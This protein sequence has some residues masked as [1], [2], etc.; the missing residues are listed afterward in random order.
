MPNQINKIA[1]FTGHTGGIY[2]LQTD[3]ENQRFFTGGADGYV[4]EWDVNKPQEGSLLVKLPQ[5]VYSILILAHVGEAWIGTASGNIHVVDLEKRQE[6]KNFQFHQRGVFDL[7]FVDGQVY[8]AGG[9]GV[10]SC[11]NA[12]TKVFTGSLQLSDKS[13]RSLSVDSLSGIIAAASSDQGIYLVDFHLKLLF[14]RPDSHANSVFAVT[15]YNQGCHLLSGGRDAFLKSW[16]IETGLT[17][18]QEIPAHNLHI[19]CIAIQESKNLALTSSMDKT[20]KLWSLQDL[21]LIKVIDFFKNKGHTSSINKVGWM[22]DN[23]FVSAGDDK[24]AMLWEITVAD[25]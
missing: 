10:I 24:K 1:E 8:A 21:R 23:R 16:K 4:V 11:W 9:D 12:K 22:N 20:I 18:L 15:F 3:S 17:V 7:K 25:I 14:G 19:H 6:T 5:P 2:G 13:I